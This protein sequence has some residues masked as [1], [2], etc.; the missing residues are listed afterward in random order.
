M[1]FLAWRAKQSARKA[2]KCNFSARMV[3]H[4]TNFATKGFKDPEILGA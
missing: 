4:Q 1:Q 3:Q 2:P